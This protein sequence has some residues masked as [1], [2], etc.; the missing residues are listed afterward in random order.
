MKKIKYVLLAILMFVTINVQ[1]ASD[2]CDSKELARLKELAKKIEF[3]YDYKLVNEKAIFSVNA[4]NLNSDLKVLIID[5]YYSDK[6]KEFKDDNTTHKG[7][8]NDF[9]PGERITVTIKGF[10]PNWCSGK[11]VLTKIVKLPYYNYFYDEEK[12]R[13]YE[14][15]KYCKQLIDSNITQKE[16]DRQ[17]ELYKKNNSG[18]DTPNK[19][20][21]KDNSSLYL[22]IGGGVLAVFIIVIIVKIIIKRRKKNML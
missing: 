6:Y 18:N 8:L 11:T 17:F 21:S 12:C 5:D 13:G 19:T 20:A 15:F 3:D 4:M 16:F 2:T 10:V 22:M 7:T 9:Q 1:A 14:N